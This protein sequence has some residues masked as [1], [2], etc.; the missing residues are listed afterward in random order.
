M[1]ATAKDMKA[2]ADAANG[3]AALAFSA[4]AIQATAP[5]SKAALDIKAK[6]DFETFCHN[7]EGAKNYL[8]TIYEKANPDEQETDDFYGA[9]GILTRETLI[10]NPGNDARGTLVYKCKHTRNIQDTDGN[11]TGIEYYQPQD[12]ATYK[13]VRFRSFGEERLEAADGHADAGLAIYK[14]EASIQNGVKISKITPEEHF[15]CYEPCDIELELNAEGFFMEKTPPI[16]QTVKG[17][18]TKTVINEETGKSEEVTTIE[19]DGCR[20]M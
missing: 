8:D 16:L 3:V 1:S 2:T 9:I 19:T 11:V 10:K 18:K 6:N 13:F 20:I 7:I 4:S 15:R 17:I 14:I 5:N 12:A